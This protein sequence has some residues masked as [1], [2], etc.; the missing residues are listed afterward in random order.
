[1]LLCYSPLRSQKKVHAL[2]MI[3]PRTEEMAVEAIQRVVG[4]RVDIQD[5]P[6]S[7]SLQLRQA[8]R[9]EFLRKDCQI[10]CAVG[11]HVPPVMHRVICHLSSI[12]LFH[13]AHCSETER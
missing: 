2:R 7:Q 3:Q 4:G 10:Y 1:M 9:K 11:V 8:I 5:I 6:H 12:F 13:I